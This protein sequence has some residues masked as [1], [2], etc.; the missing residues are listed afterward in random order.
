LISFFHFV[1]EIEEISLR[2][3]GSSRKNLEKRKNLVLSFT[4]F[5]EI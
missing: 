1:F 4:F 2:E 3:E 5:E